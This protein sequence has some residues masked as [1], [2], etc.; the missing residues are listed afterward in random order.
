MIH[1]HKIVGSQSVNR[2]GR[3]APKAWR[4]VW[5][6]DSIGKA[7]SVKRQKDT[8][9]SPLED[10][11]RQTKWQTAR[12][13]VK[14][15]KEFRTAYERH[16]LAYAISFFLGHGR[17]LADAMVLAVCLSPRPAIWHRAGVCISHRLKMPQQARCLGAG[18]LPAAG[19][20]DQTSSP[21]WRYICAIKY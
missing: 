18:P 15:K 6:L 8:K 13:K 19:L 12:T 11:R 3:V 21:L 5:N 10:Q 4:P 17:S 2:T 1:L 16:N 9:A 14:W 7:N 20:P